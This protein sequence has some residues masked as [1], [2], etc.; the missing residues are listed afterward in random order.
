MNIERVAETVAELRLFNHHQAANLLE[1]TA[2]AL[3]QTLAVLDWEQNAHG[4]GGT[5]GLL[6]VI[7]GTNPPRDT[8]VRKAWRDTLTTI[9]QDTA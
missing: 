2:K 5:E 7:N 1:A 6:R 8:T 3:G 4:S 9:E